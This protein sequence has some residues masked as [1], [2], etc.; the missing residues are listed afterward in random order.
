MGVPLPFDP[1]FAGVP[2]GLG[3]VGVWLR[4]ALS[5]VVSPSPSLSLATTSVSTSSPATGP[6]QLSSSS[7]RS[8][9][10]GWLCLTAIPLSSLRPLFP[11]I[12]E[13]HDEEE[14]GGRI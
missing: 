1:E 9:Y 14:D 12:E 2:E 10:S 4:S 5:E 11:P 6:T 3:Y 7:S 8:L 13:E